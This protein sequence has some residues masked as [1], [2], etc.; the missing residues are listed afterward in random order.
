[1][2]L[3]KDGRYI[4]CD[5]TNCAENADVLVAFHPE[6]LKQ[7]HSNSIGEGW[8]YEI[9]QGLTLHFCPSCAKNAWNRLKALQN[10]LYKSTR[11][12]QWKF[13]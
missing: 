11:N 4:A 3:G 6:L 5:G 9:R 8:L 7:S 12:R 13:E 1:M 10:D 2:I